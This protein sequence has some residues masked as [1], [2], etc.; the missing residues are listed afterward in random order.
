MAKFAPHMGDPH[1]NPQTSPKHADPHG[2]LVAWFSFK[3]RHQVHVDRRVVGWS[4][5]RH[6]DHPCAGG[7]GGKF[8]HGLL[9]KSLIE[10]EKKAK[11]TFVRRHCPG[12][13]LGDNRRDETSFLGS[14]LGPDSEPAHASRRV[15]RVH[16]KGVMQQHA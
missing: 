4:E 1:G 11:L 14:F 16:T 13:F 8:R 6:V 5:G 3:K 9:E 7:G 10:I 2:F 12:A 15:R